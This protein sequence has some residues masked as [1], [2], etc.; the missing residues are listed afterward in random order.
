MSSSSFLVICSWSR[1][2]QLLRVAV[3]TLLSSVDFFGYSFLFWQAIFRQAL[4]RQFPNPNPQAD[5]SAVRM[6]GVRR[7]GR[8]SLSNETT[9][10]IIGLVVGIVHVGIALVGIGLPPINNYSRQWYGS[11]ISKT[12]QLYLSHD[13]T[14]WIKTSIHP[15]INQNTI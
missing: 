13:V 15:S 9:V 4:F 14:D 10:C 6:S 12:L 7:I 2:C 3:Q 5:P 1:L 11:C 8:N